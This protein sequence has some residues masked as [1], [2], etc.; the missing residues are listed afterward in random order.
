ME[1]DVLLLIHILPYL[2][3]LFFLIFIILKSADSR[4]IIRN[5]FLAIIFRKILKLK[6][7]RHKGYL[8]FD[9]NFFKSQNPIISHTL[10]ILNFPIFLIQLFIKNVSIYVRLAALDF[11]PQFSPRSP[12]FSK[13]SFFSASPSFP[14]NFSFFNRLSKNFGLFTQLHFQIVIESSNKILYF[15]SKY[16]FLSNLPHRGTKFSGFS[17][18]ARSSR[19]YFSLCSHRPE[20]DVFDFWK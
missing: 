11:S 1:L 10:K 12:K 16:H 17:F 13:L 18:S 2:L 3:I 8:A 19:I 6:C 9:F 5:K 20:H 4:F 14:S 15:S 7:S